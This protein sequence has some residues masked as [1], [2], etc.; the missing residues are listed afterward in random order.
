MSM[1][2]PLIVTCVAFLVAGLA[3]VG[4]LYLTDSIAIAAGGF[5]AVMVIETIIVW[6]WRDHDDRP[7]G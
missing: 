4:G 2:K 3:G 7:S 6:R 5:A 1:M